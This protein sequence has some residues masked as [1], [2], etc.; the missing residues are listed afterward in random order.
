ML[1]GEDLAAIRGDRR[2]FSGLGFELGPGELLYVSGPNGSGKTTLL[3][4]LCGLVLPADG[5]IRW[6]GRDIHA[7]GDGYRQ[8]LLYCGHHDAV[9]DDLSALENLRV[10][11][12]LAGRRLDGAQTFAALDR[13]GLGEVAELP[14]R[15]LSR[16]QRRRLGL[17]RLG[18]TG[19]RLWVLDEPFTALDV[20][21][22]E[23]LRQALGRHLA[24]GGLAVLTTHQSVNVEAATVREVAMAV[25]A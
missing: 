2:L 23:T 6:D 1:R 10:A 12:R 24:G 9:K 11:V 17:A 21:A 4:M 3:R 14:A 8:A 15:L 20:Q 18:L 7:L 16:G 22:V 5:R 25:F 19:A 13:L